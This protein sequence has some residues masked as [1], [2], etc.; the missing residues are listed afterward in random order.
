MIYEFNADSKSS[1]LNKNPYSVP[2]FKPTTLQL[3][4]SCQ[5]IYI[6]MTLYLTQFGIKHSGE[7]SLKPLKYY[8][9]P[10]HPIY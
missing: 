7:E 3:T 6:F 10:V 5:G 4:L 1:N 2:W 9:E 8:P